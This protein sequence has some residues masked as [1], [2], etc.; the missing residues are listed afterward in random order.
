MS[1][2]RRW[3]KNKIR[4]TLTGLLCTGCLC[5]STL[6]SEDPASNVWLS[7]VEIQSDARISVTVPLAYGFVVRGSIDP[8]DRNQ[9]SVDNGNLIVP[10][11]KVH[12]TVPSDTGVPAKY[13]LQTISEHSIPIRNYSTDVREEDMES[14][15]PPREGLPVE[16]K[17]FISG[18]GSDTHHWKVVEYDP[19]WD[20]SVSSPTHFKEYQMGIDEYIFS[21]SDGIN[22]GLWL[23]GTIALDAPEDVQTH[24][25]TAAGTALI[26]SE[27]YVPVDVKVGGMQS[28]YKQVEESLKVGSIFWQ[29]IPGK[30]PEIT[31]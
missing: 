2:I 5:F 8:N 18:Y 7:V 16:L 4:L 27:K 14:E 3:K 25:Y 21:Y 13:E 12:V 31:P 22:D 30:L 10:N 23:N 19:T 6:A 26:P 17:P 9:V 28:E 20:E 11:A 15:N 29:I 1:P 24:G